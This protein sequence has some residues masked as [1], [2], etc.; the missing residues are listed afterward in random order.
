MKSTWLAALLLCVS[1]A[2]CSSLT[3][4]QD[5]NRGLKNYQEIMAGRKK[6]DQLTP[7]ERQEVIIIHTRVQASRAASGG[8][9]ECQNAR[10]E[11]KSKASELAD[12]ARR[13]RSCAE[14]EDLSDDCDSEFRRVKNA[15]S[16]YESAVSDVSS[17]CR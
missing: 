3:F 17:A 6:L 1:S 2:M 13:L 15:H 14:A 8:S 12:Y 11:A 9:R 5:F 10:S 4:A 16:D 7:Q